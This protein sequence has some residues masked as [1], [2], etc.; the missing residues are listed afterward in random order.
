MDL[1]YLSHGVGLGAVGDGGW[2]W[3]VGGV[4][5]HDLGGVG[6]IVPGIRASHEGGGSND[7]R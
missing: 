4:R 3:A 7:G 6:D 1:A 5:S 2:R